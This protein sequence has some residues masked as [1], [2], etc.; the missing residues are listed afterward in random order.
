MRTLIRWQP[1]R[2]LTIVRRQLDQLLDDLTHVNLDS[3]WIKPQDL[4]AAWI[5][6]I[7]L[8][9]AETHLVL[10]AELPGITA[11]NLDIQ[12]SRDSVTLAGE[13]CHEHNSEATRQHRT[14][15]RYGKF[16]RTIPLRI[17]V[18]PDQVTAE[19]QDGLLTLTL[20]KVTTPKVVKVA[21]QAAPEP[22][23]NA[24]TALPSLAT[25]AVAGAESAVAAQNDTTIQ[26]DLWIADSLSAR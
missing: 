12:V 13:Y 4:G 19:L 15:F 10:K 21:V 25:A 18:Q 6:A 11:D 17:P 20:P 23:V 9:D 3:A 2:D 1:V 14:E 8:R 24:E 16:H 26:D 5:P 22:A 7:E